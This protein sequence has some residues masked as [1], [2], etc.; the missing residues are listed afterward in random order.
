MALFKA[1]RYYVDSFDGLSREVWLLALV[2]FIN[3]AGSMVIPFLSLY[4]SQ[5]KGLDLK[6]IGWVMSAFGAG[7]VLG[8]WIGGKLTDRIGYYEV[9]VGSLLTS[10]VAYILLQYVNGFLPFCLGVF[11]LVLLADAFRPAIFVA[12]RGYATPENRTRAVTLVRLAINLG[13]SMGPAIGGL[14]IT[15]LSYAGL[16]WVDGV[17]C[18]LA[19]IM[20]IWTIP[21]KPPASSI[22]TKVPVADQSPYTDRIYLLFLV[23]IVLISIPFLQ[24]FSTVPLFYNEVHGLNEAQIGLLLGFNGLLIF[25]IEMPLIKYCEGRFDMFHILL[26]SVVLFILSF[27]VL[28]VFPVVAFLWVGMLFMTVGEM[29]NFPFMNRFAFDR[30]DQGPPG[31][32]MALFT[33]AWSVAHIIG[34]NLGMRSVEKWG[35]D[36]TWVLCAGCLFLAL[37]ATALLAWLMKRQAQTEEIADHASV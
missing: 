18:I 4:L 26:F 32:Y 9:M 20:L 15:T 30:S 36:V 14:I 21:K 10:G 13:F 12:L 6:Q 34:H 33:I 16:F 24:Y 22:D 17:T 28:V 1:Y 8:S 19:A 35:Y 2:T 23:I 25:L 27:I 11:V 37:A 29:L 31:A 5:D 3:R 7:S